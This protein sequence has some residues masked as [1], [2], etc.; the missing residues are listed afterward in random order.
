MNSKPMVLLNEVDGQQ[1]VEIYQMLLGQSNRI[2]ISLDDFRSLMFVLKAMDERLKTKT[3]PKLDLDE[4]LGPLTDFSPLPNEISQSDK[5]SEEQPTAS[6]NVLTVQSEKFVEYEP[7]T[8]KKAKLEFADAKNIREELLDIYCQFFC[9]RIPG[10]VYARCAGCKQSDTVHDVCRLGR[11]ERIELVFDEILAE[12]D[13][14]TM[15]C[16]LYERKI[17]SLLPYN[18]KMYISKS[19]LLKSSCWVKKLKNKIDKAL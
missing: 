3:Q 4:I 8:V 2:S 12:L 6:N 9:I 1:F 13:D 18:D 11:K 7:T 19:V 17:N 10:K 14:Y 16:A 5:V 15:Q